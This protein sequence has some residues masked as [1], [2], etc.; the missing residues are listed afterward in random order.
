MEGALVFMAILWFGIAFLVAEM[1]RSREVGYTAVLF[2]SLILSPIIGFIVALVSA[3]IPNALS[4][5]SSKSVGENRFKISLD[6][7]K[8]A[9]FKGETENAISLYQ[10]TLYY[11]SNDYDNLNNKVEQNRQALMND[12]RGRIEELKSIKS[13]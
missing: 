11:M 1:G 5:S 2:I 7:A 8:K 4:G 12:I 10:D 3:K 6:E 9:A 13:E